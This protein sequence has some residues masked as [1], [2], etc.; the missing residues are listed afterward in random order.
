MNSM[1][2]SPVSRIWFMTLPF[3]F[4]RFF[5][6]LP[7]APLPLPPLPLVSLLSLEDESMLMTRIL[8]ALDNAKFRSAFTLPES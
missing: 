7:L 6:P 2:R 1:G 4:F 8:M 3:D 5:S